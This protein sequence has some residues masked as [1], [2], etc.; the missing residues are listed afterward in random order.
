LNCV[1][2]ETVWKTPRESNGR[3]YGTPA[4]WKH[5]Q[6]AQV[7][8]FGWSRLNGYDLETGKELW[9]VNELPPQ[10]CA[11]PLIDGNAI[12]VTAT[13]IFGEPETLV[14]LP[15]YEE[16]LEAHDK[17]D[18]S[19]LT[20]DEIPKD[21][22]LIDRRASGG[23]GNSPLF[24]FASRADQNRDK[25]ISKDEWER[26]Q[27]LS[28]ERL[29][30]DPGLYSIRL[31][32]E[33]DVTTTHVEWHQKRG[34]TEVPTPLVYDGRLYLVRNG[35]IVHCRDSKSG[36]QAYRGRLGPTGG[37]YASPVGGDGKI[38]FASDRG[39]ISVVATGDSLKVLARNDLKEPI[40]A[41]PALVDGKI[42]VRTDEHL[43]AFAE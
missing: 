34:V 22:A 7:V 19:Q 38:Y 10:S 28:R 14:E 40:M 31:G 23:A 17:D 37:Y 33:G 18:D 39:V 2:G 27:T 26:L 11:T 12:F 43:F 21:L 15:S 6:G 42:Y 41:T 20:L 36:K 16:F 1:D 35:G 9:W 4:I 5:E 25:T 3:R 29:A 32:G 8:L 24:G 13:G 30:T